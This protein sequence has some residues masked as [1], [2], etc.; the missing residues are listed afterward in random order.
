VTYCV[1][2]SLFLLVWHHGKVVVPGK[3]SGVL[4][5]IL[6]WLGRTIVQGWLLTFVLF[7]GFAAGGWVGPGYADWWYNYTANHSVLVWVLST[8]PITVILWF[9]W[10]STFMAMTKPGTMGWWSPGNAPSLH[11]ISMGLPAVWGLVFYSWLLL[12]PT[13][14]FYSCYVRHLILRTPLDVALGW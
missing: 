1:L 12:T 2:M 6:G 14:P 13:L 10:H 3:E 5:G 7:F 8:P 11:R 9:I 4:F